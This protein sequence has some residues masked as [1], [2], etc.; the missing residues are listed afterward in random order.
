MRPNHTSF[1]FSFHCTEFT[2]HSYSFPLELLGFLLILGSNKILPFDLVAGRLKNGF[3][4]LF[5]CKH[6]LCLLF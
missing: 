4:L 1:S 5:F 3:Y 2:H 6:F